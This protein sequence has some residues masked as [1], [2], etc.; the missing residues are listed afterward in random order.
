M[1]KDLFHTE[2]LENIIE[3]MVFEE[4]DKITREEVIEFCHCDICIQDIAAISLNNLPPY[5]RTQMLYKKFPAPQEAKYRRVL[6][7]KVREEVIKAIEI[8]MEHP[9]H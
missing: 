6:K 4:I 9:N 2:E 5:Y 3:E 8:T 1:Y 7:A